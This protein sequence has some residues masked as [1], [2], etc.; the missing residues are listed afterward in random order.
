MQ[1]ELNAFY[2]I[3]QVLFHTLYM[4]GTEFLSIFENNHLFSAGRDVFSRAVF[5][6]TFIL[7]IICLVCCENT[8]SLIRQPAQSNI[9]WGYN[10]SYLIVEQSHKSCKSIC[11]FTR[12]FRLVFSPFILFPLE[13]KAQ[14]KSSLKPQSIIKLPTPPKCIGTRRLLFG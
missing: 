13:R 10:Y 2:S 9:V 8:T 3:Q 14:D 7:T 12:Q 4:A 11:L 6:I 1:T 5:P